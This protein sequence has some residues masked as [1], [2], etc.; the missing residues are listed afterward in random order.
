[1]ENGSSNR[2]SIRGA[3]EHAI[4]MWR[5]FKRGFTRE[6]IISNLKTLLGVVPL[7]ILVW[8]YAEQQQLVTDKATVR[9]AITS[10]DPAHRFVTLL[11]PSDGTLEL[12]LQ[13]APS[14][15]DRV[16]SELEEQMMSQPLSV[17]VGGE[18]PEGQQ[19]LPALDE[20]ASNRT[21]YS[22][23]VTVLSCSPEMLSIRVDPVEDRVVSVQAPPDTPGLIKAVFQP[24]QVTMRGSSRLL[25]DLQ[26]R[27]QLVAV[28][29]LTDEP[30]LKQP[31]E[32]PNVLI[33]LLPQE[34][35]TF[36]PSSVTADLTVGQA[37]QTLD[38]SPVPV[39]VLATKWLMDNYKFDYK[40]VLAEPVTLIGPPEQIALVDPRS[41]KLIAVVELGNDDAGRHEVKPLTFQNEG[42]PDGVRVK[43]ESAPRTMQIG[44]D[45]R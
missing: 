43:A 12:T 4:D 2:Y 45:P 25:D 26:R 37:E 21:F 40:E 44:I 36:E 17:E 31:G 24:A 7:T 42:L 13:G 22:K 27:G 18:V 41:P 39:K 38:V 23:G 35:I 19:L 20:I 30:V 5:D 16:K 28:A 34:N 33:H 1:M 10:A 6:N 9:I 11:S 3:V 8:I 32:H 29:D 14:G 15:I